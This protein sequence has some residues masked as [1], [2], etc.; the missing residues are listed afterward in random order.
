MSPNKQAVVFD[1]NGTIL[2][3]TSLCLRAT[4]H[5][6]QK[7]GIKPA[8]LGKYQSAYTL[9]MDN[10]YIALGCTPLQLEEHRSEIVRGWIH[11]YLENQ[12]TVR[13]R[14]GVKPT[15]SDLASRGHKVAVLSNYTVDGIAQQMDRFALASHFDVVLANLP[16][17]SH[18]VM[19]RKSKG[20]RLKGFVEGH[21]IRHALVVGDTPEEIEIAHA[22]GY[23]GVAIADGV[24][25]LSR[26]KAAKPDF[27]IRRLDEV[28]SIA[29]KVF[30]AGGGR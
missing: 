5:V 19:Q 18:R 10:M 25:S 6:L 26:L 11:Y 28:P 13:L 27:L 16:E 24:C 12:K 15:L 4:N 14:K 1:W 22:Y 17:E 7:I 9:P 21:D 3:D 20:E 2:A 8:T 29:R 23:L 30:G